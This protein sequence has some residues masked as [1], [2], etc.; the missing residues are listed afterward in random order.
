[1]IRSEVS[2]VVCKSYDKKL[3]DAAVK[4]AVDSIGGIGSF[5]RPDERI[6][7]KPNFLYPSSADKSVTTHPSVIS[8]VLKL[9]KDEGCTRVQIGDSPA[10]G[11]CRAAIDKLSLGE[12]ELYGY[13]VADMSEDVLTE[14]PEGKVAK[15]FHFA[16]EVTEADA[17]IGVCKMKTHQL[18]RIT[19][20]VKNMYGLIC[21]KWKA[22][23][24][25]KFPNAN[26]F[27]KMLADIHNATPQRLHV[28]DAVTA[29]EGNGPASGTP[30]K[31]NL[32]LA[33]RDPV[34]LDTVFCSL[35]DLTPGL[36]PTNVMGSLAGLGTMDPDEI[37]ILLTDENGTRP[38]SV[39]EFA[40]KYGKPDYD[41]MR[42][43]AKKRSVLGILSRMS[44]DGRKP[45]IDPSKCVKC[46]V[47]VEHCPVDGK[48]VTF[49]N[50]RTNPPVN[51]YKKCI[52][53]YCCQELC[54]QKA[55]SVKGH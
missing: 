8:A 32:I 35:I 13:A 42:E 18:E 33:S 50:G 10:A 40:Q 29:M 14:N 39:A 54:P 25:V 52:R 16:R 20:A 36:V 4:T 17:I 41:V 7:V 23:G 2:A 51:N 49:E 3:V 34:A 6:L 28:M 5:I 11:S 24:H 45:V 26:V 30:T 15:D 55:I 46:G 22:S 1:M 47:C 27:A 31:M 44:G 48:A 53:C 19:G 12:E 37:E 43:N 38:C 9:L 21:G